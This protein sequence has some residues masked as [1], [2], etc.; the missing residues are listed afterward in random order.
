MDLEARI[1]EVLQERGLIGDGETVGDFVVMA[2]INNFSADGAG[3]TKYANVIPGENGIPAHRLLGLIEVCG[4]MLRS[5]D[6]D[7]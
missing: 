5:D 7:E 2:E 6:D 4:D 3:S 1:G